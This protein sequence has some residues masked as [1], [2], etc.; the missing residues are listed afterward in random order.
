M[1]RSIT[2]VKTA[3]TPKYGSNS[4]NKLP[5]ASADTICSKP[6][7]FKIMCNV[8]NA[9]LIMNMLISVMMGIGRSFLLFV[10]DMMIAYH[11]LVT[12]VLCFKEG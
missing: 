1:G 10:L 4:P 9:T 3:I 5:N 12:K 7:G 6:V 2:F 8:A 11:I